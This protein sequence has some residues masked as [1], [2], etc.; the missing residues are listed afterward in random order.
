VKPALPSEKDIAALLGQIR[1]NVAFEHMLV[2]VL[3]TA[4]ASAA[5]AF[6]LK[7]AMHVIAGAIGPGALLIDFLGAMTIGF[8]VFLI[9]FFSSIVFGAPLFATLEKRKLRRAWPYVAAAIGIEFAALWLI[10][11]RFPL[12]APSPS[13]YL[14]FLPGLLAAI[15][16][17][18]SMRPV[19]AA[20]ERSEQAPSVI[21]LH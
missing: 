21:R 15:L 4:A 19:W 1:A 16:F 10:F 12:D 17:V 3:A 7:F 18:R 11:G 6:V 8:S 5:V 14:L 9:G 2:A 20:A 13:R